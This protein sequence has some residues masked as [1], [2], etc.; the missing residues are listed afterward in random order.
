M[1][2]AGEK[3]SGVMCPENCAA[4]FSIY[5]TLIPGCLPHLS[6]TSRG[7]LEHLEAKMSYG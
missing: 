3:G 6:I 7:P 1:D 2:A 5:A 4:P